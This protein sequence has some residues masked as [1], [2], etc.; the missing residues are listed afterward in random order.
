[1]ASKVTVFFVIIVLLL[2]HSN[3][4]SFPVTSAAKEKGLH[5]LEVSK[6]SSALSNKGYIAMSMILE[7]TLQTFTPSELIN[8]NNT[9]L[10][11]FCPTDNTFFFLNLSL[12]ILHYP[13]YDNGEVAKNEQKISN[14]IKDSV[15]EKV[16]FSLSLKLLILVMGFIK[17]YTLLLL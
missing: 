12:Q 9:T 8:N 3:L 13:W 14:T 15:D 16:E 4:S 6:I 11:I 7:Q 2:F 1:M 17:I 10:T 5:G